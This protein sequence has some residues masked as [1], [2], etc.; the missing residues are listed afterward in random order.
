[1]AQIVRRT[2]S[3]HDDARSLLRAVYSTEVDLMDMSRDATGAR[4]SAS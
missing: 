3:R 1:M 2:M 4:F